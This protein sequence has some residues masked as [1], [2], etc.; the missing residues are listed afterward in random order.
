MKPGIG[1]LHETVIAVST[2]KFNYPLFH[3]E[4]QCGVI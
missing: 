2:S 3:F 4:F 1:F